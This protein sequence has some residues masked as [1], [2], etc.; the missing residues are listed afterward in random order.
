MHEGSRRA[1][2]AAFVANLGIA[3]AKFVGFSFT[4]AASMLAEAVH[5]VADTTNQGLLLFG[6]RLASRKSDL[7]HQFGYARERYFWAFVVALVIFSLG[8]LFALLEGFEKLHDPHELE[9]IEWAVGILLVAVVL[10]TF[11]LRTAVAE[12]SHAKAGESWW[13]FVHHS[14]VPELPV[15]LLE[16]L[17]ALVG[18]AFAL[19]GIALA[20]VTGNSSWDAV[21][22]LAIGVLL[23]V[24]AI[25]LIVEMKSLL[26]G[27][28]ASPVVE[29]AIRAVIEKQPSVRRLI[30]I[31]TQ[32][33]GPDDILLGAKIELDEELNIA[34][35]AREI[36][37]IERA[38]RAE[39][40]SVRLI[41]VEPD[42]FK[43]V[44]SR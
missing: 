33:L 19:A 23:G 6:N 34:G 9:S 4:G 11:S 37:A 10:E 17:G 29:E 32:H 20:A 13:A 22:S 2:I 27:E 21:G 43:G 41:Y 26:I 3:I 39:V 40:P 8:S 31:R 44:T 12:A 16:D 18:L 15:V 30:H 24:I 7:Q 35:V 38:V 1:I 25:I 42:V 5:S 36:D 14:K 28:S